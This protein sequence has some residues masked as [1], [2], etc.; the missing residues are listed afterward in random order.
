MKTFLVI[1]GSSGIGKETV[2]IL[3][4]EGHHVFA[5]FKTNRPESQDRLNLLSYDAN[6]SFDASSLP[7]RIDGLVYCPGTVRLQPFLRTSPAS[8]LEDFQTNV[9]GLVSV[10]K[11]VVPLLKKSDSASV[12]AFSSVAAGVGF[13]YH[14][15]IAISKGAIESLFK[16]LAAE[17]SPKIRFNVIAPSIVKTPLTDKL[18]NSPEKIEANE[19]RHPLNKIGSPQQLAE[20]VKFL[21]S[22]TSGWMTGQVLHVDG[23]I[24]TIK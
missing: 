8:I 2:D 3:L 9:L 20:N 1:G 16:T 13:Q 21:L 11:E 7:E 14:T 17:F 19:K 23:G 24:S 10:L 6:E 12:V 22:D 4:K 5:T 15:S 18:L